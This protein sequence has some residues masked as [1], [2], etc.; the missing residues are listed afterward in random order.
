VEVTQIA[1]TRGIP[2]GE[3]CHSPNTFEEFDDPASLFQ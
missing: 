1:A 2:M 3:D